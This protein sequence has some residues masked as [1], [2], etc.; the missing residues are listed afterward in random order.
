MSSVGFEISAK[1]HSLSAELRSGFVP[2]SMDSSRQEV[3]LAY[4]DGLRADF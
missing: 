2:S 3:R 4:A 1:G